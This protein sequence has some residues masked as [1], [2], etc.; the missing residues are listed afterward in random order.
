MMFKDIDGTRLSIDYPAPQY[1][2][3][4]LKSLFEYYRLF[5]H[6]R[7]LLHHQSVFCDLGC[8]LGKS[9]L[10]V[11]AMFSLRKSIG[12]EAIP[13]MHKVS[14]VQKI[15][16]ERVFKPKL[17]NCSKIKFICGDVLDRAEDWLSSDVVFVNSLSWEDE[18]LKDVTEK[19]ELLK[20]GSEIFTSSRLIS[21]F[22]ELTNTII[23]E[24]NW[25]AI[26][27]Y[28]YVRVLN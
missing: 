16:F 27:V 12:I 26:P 24:M 7:R 13:K 22:L 3:G 9:N 18:I 21:D 20:P 1:V 19:L 28:L 14:L 11:A 6:S 10:V 15:I 17:K 23:T 5:S 25:G 2:Y 8:G 4:E